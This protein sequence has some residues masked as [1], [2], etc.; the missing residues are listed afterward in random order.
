MGLLDGLNHLL[1]FVAPA[2][3]VALLLTGGG[4]IFLKKTAVAS[5]W[6]T[7][8]AINFVVGCLVLAAGLVLLGRDGRMLTYVA[9]VVACATSQWVLLRGW[10]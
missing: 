10:R 4:R 3:F 6:R 9:L 5:S 1:N 2:L 7:Q 8:F